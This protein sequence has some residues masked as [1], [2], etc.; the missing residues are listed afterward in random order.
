MKTKNVFKGM[1]LTAAFVFA[2]SSVFADGKISVSPYLK[3]SYAVVSVSPAVDDFSSLAIYNS[4]GE[5]V[6]SSDKV[7]SGVGY[8]KLFDFSKM[9]DGKYKITARNNKANSVEEYFTVKSGNVVSESRTNSVSEEDVRIWKNSDY[10]YVSHLNRNFNSINVTLEDERG[11]L[12]YEKSF[13]AE[14]AYSEKFDVSSLPKGNY[15]LSF[16]SGD[17]VFNYEFNK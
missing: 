5:L 17:N 10:V 11:S 2:G 4:Q 14:L 6:Y 12:I 8:T 13:P 15:S 3:T 1:L 7:E 16:V 9:E